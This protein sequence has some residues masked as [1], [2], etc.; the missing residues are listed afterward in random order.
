MEEVEEEG[1]PMERPAVSTNLDPRDLSNTEQP[2]R[3]H[4]LAGLRPLT[5]MQQRTACPG[6]NERSKSPLRDLRSQGMGRTGGT[7]ED[8]GASFEQ[9]ERRGGIE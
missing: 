4:T 8:V 2:P 1:N 3:Q 6:F 7:W 9:E 5:H